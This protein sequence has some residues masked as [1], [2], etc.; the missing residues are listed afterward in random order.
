MAARDLADKIISSLKSAI[1]K[2]GT[3]FTKASPSIANAAIASTITTYLISNTKV[4]VSYNGPI[5]A[6]GTESIPSD[7][8]TVLGVCAPP[9]GT[10]FDSW[11]SSLENNIVSGFFIGVGKIVIPAGTF[12]SFKKGI[13]ISREDL[14]SIHEGN[15]TKDDDPQ[16]LIWEKISSAILEWLN[17]TIGTP[18]FSAIGK[19]SPSGVA[20]TTKVTVS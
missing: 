8:L 2:D 16:K 15:I 19:A 12:P 13:S 4:N 6:G 7:D 10:D 20:K 9:S 18:S 3:K 5:P 11:I 17:S 1:G 14:K